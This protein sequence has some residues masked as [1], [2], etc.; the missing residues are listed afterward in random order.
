MIKLFLAPGI[1]KIVIGISLA[2]YSM[3]NI[4]G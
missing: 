2:I 3:W 1:F 4:A